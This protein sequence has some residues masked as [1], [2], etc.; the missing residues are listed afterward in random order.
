MLLEIVA[1]PLKGER[2]R[3]QR[4]GATI[5]RAIDNTIRLAR[6]RPYSQNTRSLPPPP[7]KAPLVEIYGTHRAFPRV[8]C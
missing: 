7:S 3:I 6:R 5:G 1:G 2:R 4:E 8:E